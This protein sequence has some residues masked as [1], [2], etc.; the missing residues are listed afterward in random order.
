MKE[1]RAKIKVIIGL[2]LHHQLKLASEELVRR[3]LAQESGPPERL[4]GQGLAAKVQE[5]RAFPLG[6]H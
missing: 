6:S 1:L 3:S 5:F 2:G 4:T